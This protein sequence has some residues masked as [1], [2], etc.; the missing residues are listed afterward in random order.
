MNLFEFNLELINQ[1]VGLVKLVIDSS[2][3]WHFRYTLTIFLIQD[4]TIKI[5]LD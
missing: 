2:F 5:L 4:L 1:A 3:Q